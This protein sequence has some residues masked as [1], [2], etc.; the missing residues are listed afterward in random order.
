[1]ESSNRISWIS[2]LAEKPTSFANILP[3][4]SPVASRSPSRRSSLG[5]NCIPA[6]SGTAWTS[7][8]RS[9]STNGLFC[10]ARHCA[11]TTPTTTTK[12]R[13][14]AP[15]TWHLTPETWHLFHR[16]LRIAEHRVVHLVQHAH[17]PHINGYLVSG[18][19]L[20]KLDAAGVH[21]LPVKGALVAALQL[22]IPVGHQVR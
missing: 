22:E 14:L 21:V 9:H 20:G 4:R 3:S 8:A 6:S 1:M 16:L 10:A 17:I 18:M 2:S 19:G 15:N 7:S 13:N 11:P 5:S 12:I